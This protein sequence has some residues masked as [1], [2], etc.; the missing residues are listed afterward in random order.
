MNRDDDFYQQAIELTPEQVK[1]FSSLKRAVGKCR[2]ANILFY[3]C[4][5]TLGGINGNNVKSICGDSDIEFRGLDSES[6]N[7]LQFKLY[8]SV[9]TECSFADDNHFVLLHDE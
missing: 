7:C 5:E 3:Q 6:P 9:V 8:P 2:R 1:A 4:L